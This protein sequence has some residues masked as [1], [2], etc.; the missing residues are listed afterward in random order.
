MLSH[1]Y[2]QKI[3]CVCLCLKPRTVQKEV[4]FA[5]KCEEKLNWQLTMQ[6]ELQLESNVK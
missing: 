6:Q 1:S 5:R 4:S 3:A 2:F